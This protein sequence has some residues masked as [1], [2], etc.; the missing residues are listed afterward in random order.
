[1]NIQKTH[2]VFDAV[3]DKD[4]RC[5]RLFS[6]GIDRGWRKRLVKMVQPHPN[7]QVLDHYVAQYGER[8]L[9]SPRARGFNLL[10]YILPWFVFAAAGTLLVLLLRRWRR[11]GIEAKAEIRPAAAVIDPYAERI[12]KELREFEQNT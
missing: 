5:N 6:F 1:M 2:F 3:A 7:Q 4:D 12:E 8:I 11:G 10:A 9:A